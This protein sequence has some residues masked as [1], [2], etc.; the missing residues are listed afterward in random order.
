MPQPFPTDLSSQPGVSNAAPVDSLAERRYLIEQAGSFAVTQFYADGFD[1]LTPRERLL[2]YHLAEAGIAG[3]PIYYDQIAPYGL[4]LK[5]LLEGIWTHPEG[6]DADAL[7]KI[8][9]YTKQ[10]WIQHGNYNQDSSRK[11]L[12]EFT[13]AELRSVAH[14]AFK[15]GANFGVNSGAQLDTLLARLEKPVFDANYKTFLTSK[16]PPPGQDVLTASGNN[17]Y[18]NVTREE[19]GKITEQYALN[20]RIV[21]RDSQV[22]EEV[23]RA[24]TPDGKVPP[25]RYAEYIRRINAH[26]EQAAAVAEPSQAADLRKLIRY[27]QTGEKSDWY[28]YCIAW[29]KSAPTVDAIN[30]FIEVY[31]DPLGAKGAFES[32]VSFVDTDQT[33]LMHAFADNAQYFEN[34]APWIDAYKKQNVQPPVANVITVVSEAGEGGPISAAGINLPNEQD[35]RQ[36]V[37]TKSVLLFNVSAAFAQ[38]TGEKSLRE[39]SSTEE[40]IERGRQYYSESRKLMV[41][42]HEVLG[43]GSGKV[44]DNLA[45]DPRIYLKEYYSTLEEARAD[46][47]ALWDFA[48]PKLTELG[49][50]DQQELLRAAYDAE[51]RAGLTLLYRYPHG[52]QIEED[53]DRGTQMI[54]HYLM[55]NFGCIAPVMKDGKIYLRVVDY[56]KMHAG[57]GILLVEMMRIKAEGDY[58]AIRNLV[59]T[60][61]VKLNPQWRDQVQE[62]AKR[63]NLPTRGAFVSPIVEPIRDAT[64][65]LV[66]ARLRYTFDLAEVMLDYSR[67]SLAYLAGSTLSES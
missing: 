33:K 66:D 52:E 61:G 54:V 7:E 18:E 46:L 27:Y 15:N 1:R 24:G 47:V 39:F 56:E 34:R 3:D 26:L 30:G 35:I 41:A 58:D 21:K 17:L 49:I 44:S 32:V 29:A 55:E 67:K 53:H 23:W 31:L 48:D 62:R 63:I 36:Q 59:S 4:E 14:C 5:Q 10:V 45:G 51:A 43:H 22:F 65:K 42:M 9:S 37:G 2:A 11:F 6:I 25:G 64:G 28:A 40:E 16:T 13:S 57:A 20:S 12:P 8:R 60:Y 50:A 38:A 19:A